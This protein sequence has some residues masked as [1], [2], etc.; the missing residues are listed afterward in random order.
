MSLFD[1]LGGVVGAGASMISSR[2]QYKYQRALQEQAAQLNYDYGQKSLQNSPTSTRQGLESAGYNPMLAVQNATSGANS[3]WTSTGQANG[4]DYAS[5]I[6]QLVS[7][8]QN[9][10]RVKN[11]TEQT[12]SNVKL[13]DA[14]ARKNSA[15]ASNAEA[16]NPFIS[17]REQA[18]IGRLSAETSKLQRETQYFDAL[19]KN[20][21]E[22]RRINEMGINL[23]YKSAIYGA[24]QSYNAQTYSANKSYQASKYGADVNA[25]TQRGIKDFRGPFGF[26]HRGYY[27]YTVKEYLGFRG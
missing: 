6:S 4:T 5:G 19:E 11:E 23:N 17:K 25:E 18:N 24:N 7:N 21:V 10:Q 14:M 2:Q 12:D 20:L 26:G 27:P 16:E 1:F 9:M 15:E 8:A 3:G 22:M 13:N